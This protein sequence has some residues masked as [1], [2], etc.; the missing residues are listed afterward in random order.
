MNKLLWMGALSI[1]ML[2]ESCSIEKRVYQSGF[3]ISGRHT[4]SNEVRTSENT[5]YQYNSEKN[6]SQSPDEF[7]C[8]T[9]KTVSTPAV[10]DS[11]HSTGSYTNKIFQSTAEEI[12]MPF[13]SIPE[14]GELLLAKYE[15][16]HKAK[17]KIEKIATYL[18][19][20]ITLG[21]GAAWILFAIVILGN[22]GDGAI[23]GDGILILTFLKI[24]LIGL[25]LLIPFA[26]TY[27]VL[28]IITR[29]QRN[30]LRRMGLMK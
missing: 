27:L 15:K 20:L 6:S 10:L 16:N 7:P 22:I 9:L 17:H 2:M 19:A 21:V 13:D 25:I 26:I 5:K 30:K 4:T 28:S 18:M 8:D 23:D 24:G 14:E 11:I 3:Y 12:K 1:L 29:K